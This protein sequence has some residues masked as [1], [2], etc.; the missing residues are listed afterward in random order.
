[1]KQL[2][3]LAGGRQLRLMESMYRHEY[4]LASAELEQWIRE[5]MLTATS[6]EYG[7][8]FEHLLLLRSKFDDWKLRMEAESER[9]AQCKELAEKLIMA[10]SPYVED[11]ERRQDQ[12][13]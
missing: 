13:G 3:K 8:D 2:Q 11:V 6:E 7:Q 12:L 10:D 9:F 4:L 5:Q 1:M